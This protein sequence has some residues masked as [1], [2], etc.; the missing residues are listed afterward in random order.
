MTEH[1]AH[2]L[3]VDDHHEIRELV[4]GLLSRAGYSVSSVADGVQMRRLLKVQQIDLV[5][6][7]LMLPGDDRLTLCRDL[8]AKSEVPVI[9]LTARGEE[10]DRVLGLEMGADDYLAKPF[11]GRELIARI[12]AVLRRARALPVGESK[13]SVA[14]WRFDRWIFDLSAR[15]LR[16]VSDV[17][18]PLSTSEFN[19]LRV[20]IERPGTVLTREQLLDLTR[21]RDA[22]FVD[23]SIDTRISRLRRKIELDPQNPEIIKTVWGGGYIFSAEVVRG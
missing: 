20:F 2:I 23:R 9:M 10:F 16:S 1:Q 3:V 4:A 17:V 11:G 15:R 14:A 22:D 5:V 19:L 8:R 13:S 18:V 21:G 7:D 6:L 12:R